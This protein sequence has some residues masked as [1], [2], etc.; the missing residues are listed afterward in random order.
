MELQR[1]GS[2]LEGNDNVNNLWTSPKWGRLLR[3][4]GLVASVLLFW[5]AWQQGFSGVGA[6]LR[7]SIYVL[8]GVLLWLPWGRLSKIVWKRLF[9]IFCVSLFMLVFAQMYEVLEKYSQLSPASKVDSKE[10]LFLLETG[11]IHRANKPRPPIDRGVMLFFVLLQ[12][13]VLIF[14]RYPKAMS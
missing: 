4:L 7:S 11:S 12:V 2:L 13:P 14:Q 8:V 5:Q 1:E 3:I 6:A 10:S 9:A